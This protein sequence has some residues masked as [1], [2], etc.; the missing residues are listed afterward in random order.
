MVDVVAKKLP[1]IK[2]LFRKYKTERAYLFGSAASGQFTEK[3]DVDF[4]FS[5]PESMDYEVYADSY[6]GL[7]HELQALLQRDVE[8][9]A[10]KTL[11]NPF[12]IE[13]INKNKVSLI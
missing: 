1:Q 7:L 13:S 11:K 2:E 3:S 9:V 8:L 10:E 5:F 12:L 6:F 4:L